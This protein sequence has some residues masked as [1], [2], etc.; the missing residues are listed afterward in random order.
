MLLAPLLGI[1]ALA[2]AVLAAPADRITP[3]TFAVPERTAWRP[4][5]CRSVPVTCQGGSGAR[6]RLPAALVRS[7][8]L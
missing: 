3:K 5:D 1:V 7:G 4:L 2:A 6:P 8:A